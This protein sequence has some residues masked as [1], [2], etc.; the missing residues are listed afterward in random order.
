MADKVTDSDIK[1]ALEC[2]KKACVNRCEGCP[3]RDRIMCALDLRKDAIDLINRQQAEIERLTNKCEDCAGCSEWKCDC[4][5]IKS[6]AIKEFWSKLITK[7]IAVHS[8]NNTEDK[9]I[10]KFVI[11]ISEG[12]NL[13]KEM[14][15]V[16]E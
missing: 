3:Y 6:E 4:S 11:E 10:T 2:C 13:V 12:D 5:L 14:T 15:E 1:K 8:Y 9:P 7:R 16:N